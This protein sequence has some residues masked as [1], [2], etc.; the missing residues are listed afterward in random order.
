MLLYLFPHARAGPA[1]K[2]EAEERADAER[3]RMRAAFSSLY[4]A[5]HVQRADCLWC[6][7]PWR[8]LGIVHIASAAAAAAGDGCTGFALQVVVLVHLFLARL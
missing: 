7:Q 3:E 4:P 5:S 8:R 1:S 6:L 2:T